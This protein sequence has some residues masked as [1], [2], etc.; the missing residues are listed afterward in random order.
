MNLS[1]S[2]IIHMLCNFTGWG[3]LSPLWIHPEIH[4]VSHAGDW[5]TAMG[6]QPQAK[7]F[8]TTNQ[9]WKVIE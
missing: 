6:Q 4:F 9:L 1:P 3:S 7:P 5:Y 8:T 2:C